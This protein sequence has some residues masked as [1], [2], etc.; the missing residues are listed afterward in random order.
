MCVCVCV[1][2]RKLTLAILHGFL[3]YSNDI[4]QHSYH[5]ILTFKFSLIRCHLFIYEFLIS[6]VENSEQVW[7]G[8]RSQ[9]LLKGC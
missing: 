2:A 8:L 7:P 9:N 6:L 5:R 1:C 4:N 3:F